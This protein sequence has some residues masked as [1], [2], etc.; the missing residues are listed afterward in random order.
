VEECKNLEVVKNVIYYGE[1]NLFN[2]MRRNKEYLS[3]RDFVEY[4]TEDI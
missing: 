4:I 2:V 1:G 3:V